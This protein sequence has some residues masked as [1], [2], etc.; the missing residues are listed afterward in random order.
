MTN[1]QIDWPERLREWTKTESREL[2]IEEICETLEAYDRMK[3]ERDKLKQWQKDALKFIK[4]SQN[5][6]ALM[7]EL[8]ELCERLQQ[9][10]EVNE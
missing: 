3:G 4:G 7:P 5:Y 6:V 9:I 1:E 2:P 10:N 8:V